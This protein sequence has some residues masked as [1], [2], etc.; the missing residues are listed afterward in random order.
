M[1]PALFASFYHDR[2]T[3]LV[4]LVNTKL[5][6]MNFIGRLGAVVILPVQ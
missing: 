4:H 1:H 5:P 3:S 6:D 2:A